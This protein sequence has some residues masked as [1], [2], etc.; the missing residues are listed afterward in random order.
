MTGTIRPC[1]GWQPLRAAAAEAKSFKQRRDGRNRTCSFPRG[2]GVFCLC[3]TSR[4]GPS[5]SS[6]SLSQGFRAVRHEFAG[7]S[8]INDGAAWMA[9]R[10]GKDPGSGLRPPFPARF[11]RSFRIHTP[12]RLSRQYLSPSVPACWNGADMSWQ[13]LAEAASRLGVPCLVPGVDGGE[14]LVLVPLSAYE[15]LRSGKTGGPGLALPAFEPDRP[16]S[17]STVL[18]ETAENK[19]KEASSALEGAPLSALPSASAVGRPDP[20]PTVRSEPGRRP[21]AAEDRFYFQ[22]EGMGRG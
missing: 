10:L 12:L 3:T 19:P 8:W 15:S 1:R 14:P 20:A 11:K 9:S 22:E 2:R 7:G 5:P 6:R 13:H 17:T 18:G 16:S 4:K 21:M